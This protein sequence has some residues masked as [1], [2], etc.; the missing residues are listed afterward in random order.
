MLIEST[1]LAELFVEMNISRTLGYTFPHVTN[2]F[3]QISQFFEIFQFLED[4]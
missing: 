4:V 1:R 3:D 2:R